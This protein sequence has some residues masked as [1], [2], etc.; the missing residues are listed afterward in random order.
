MTP[1]SGPLWDRYRTAGQASRDAWAR[2]H[3]LPADASDREHNARIGA[4]EAT[5]LRA[6]EWWREATDDDH[7]HG[8]QWWTDDDTNDDADGR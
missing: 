4:C 1:R 3:E 7:A 6:D 8:R 2:L 5:D